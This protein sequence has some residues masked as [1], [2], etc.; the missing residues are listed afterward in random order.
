M[1]E[2]SSLDNFLWSPLQM[3]MLNFQFSKF[4]LRNEKLLTYHEMWRNDVFMEEN[5]KFFHGEISATYIMLD[6][7]LAHVLGTADY[8][9]RFPVFRWAF[10][11]CRSIYPSKQCWLSCEGSKEMSGGGIP[12]FK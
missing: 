7:K 12:A 6:D 2:T 1:D 8:L 10:T 3:Y 4:L 9:M 5:F 11:H